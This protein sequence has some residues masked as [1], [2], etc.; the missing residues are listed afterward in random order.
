MAKRWVIPDI[1]GY[2]KTLKSMVTDVVRP[3]RSDEIYFLGDYV[4]RGPD[5]KG[6]ID[7]I[8]TMQVDGYNVTALKGNH[9]DFMVELYDAEKQSVNPWWHNFGNKKHKA[10]L[11]IGGK[12][13][14][15]SFGATHIRDV[16]ADYI[17]WMRNLKHYVELDHFVLVHAG[18]NFKNEDP[19]ADLRAMMWLRDYEI[20]PEKIGGRRIIHGH[21]PVNMELI[22]MT[23]KNRIYKF[24]DLDNGPYMSGKEGYGNLVALELNSMEMVIQY[25]MD[26]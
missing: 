1:H 21:V 17:D 10:W 16:P 9:E 5:S 2:I 13:T 22:T 15:S 14:L 3:M 8:R 18:L 12:A 11:D 24:I 20:K 7:F 23:I 6:V 26:M 25:N 4:D 19:Y